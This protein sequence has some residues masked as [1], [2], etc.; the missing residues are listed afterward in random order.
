M[1]YGYKSN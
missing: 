1:H